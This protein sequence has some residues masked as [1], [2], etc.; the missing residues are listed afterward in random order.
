MRLQIYNPRTMSEQ[1]DIFH[2]EN[3]RVIPEKGKVLISEPFLND[4]YFGRSVVLLVEHDATLGSMGF[5]LNK[6]M[7]Q[8]M[9]EFFPEFENLPDIPLF[10]GGP[11]GGNRL[12]FIHTLGNI[13]PGAID[14]GEGL[15]F[16]GDFD[17]IKMYLAEGN[18]VENKIKFFMGYSGWNQKQLEEEIS[19]NSWLV[20][21]LENS[22][23]MSAVDEA[24]WKKALQTL[25][26][27]YKLWANFPKQP[28]MN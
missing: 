3:N 4:R 7:K 26:N 6:P 24:V 12:F 10:Q 20:S 18:P 27:R 28:F 9:N 5:V 11:V 17:V 15:Y 25:G 8:R 1:F 23:M 22:R 21:Q 14:I 16:D 13:I 2:I 19:N